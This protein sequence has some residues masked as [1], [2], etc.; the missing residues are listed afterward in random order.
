M[1]FA[2][3]GHLI[4]DKNIHQIP[5][6]WVNEDILYSPEIN[7]NKVKCHV[8]GIKLTPTQLMNQPKEQVRKKVLETTLFAQNELN[9]KLIQLGALLTSVTSGGQWLNAQKEYT[10]FLNHGDSYTAAVTIQAVLK[11]LKRFNKSPSEAILAVVGAY[12]IIG[13][14]VSKILVPQ[15]KN[16]ILI[17][18]RKEKLEKLSENIQGNFETNLDLNKTKNA[19]VVITATNHPTALLKSK[20]L[21]ENTLAIDVSQPPNIS[22]ALCEKRPDVHRFDGGYVENPKGVPSLLPMIPQDKTFACVAEVIMQAIENDRSN[23]VG[24]IDINYLHTTE[25]WGKKYGFKLKE[26]TN[27]GEPS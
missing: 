2:I 4:D 9:V 24:S 1:K 5:K 18:R 3:M 14:A 20:H 6:N 19:D 25:R 12:G 23:H 8:I 16:S 15:F 27:F 10:G 7:I 26:L 13:E 21:K 17:G 22:P 11:A